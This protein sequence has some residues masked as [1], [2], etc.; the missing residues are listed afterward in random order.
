MQSY[1]SVSCGAAFLPVIIVFR[2]TDSSEMH[3]FK[4]IF[5]L[6]LLIAVVYGVALPV[7]KNTNRREIDVDN[8]Y[9]QEYA[10]LRHMLI[11]DWGYTKEYADLVNFC[12]MK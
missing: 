6:A 4:Y 10:A 9:L 12:D 2:I 1:S 11:Y 3:F 5:P 8:D 7:D